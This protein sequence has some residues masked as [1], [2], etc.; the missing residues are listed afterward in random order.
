[1]R[2][3]RTANLWDAPA[4]LPCSITLRCYQ[5]AARAAVHRAH[6]TVRSTLVVLPTGTG[7]TALAGALGLDVKARGSRTLFLA[8]TITLCDQTYESM[9]RMGLTVGVEQADR[10]VAWPLPDVVV[11]SVATMRGKRLQT[12]PRDAFALIVVD[13][14]HRAPG[15]TL[16]AAIL[17]HFEGA[18]VVGLSATPDRTDGLAMANV[19]ESTAYEMT[20]L[21]AM[22]AGWLAPLDI[23]TAH[24]QWDVQAIKEKAGEVDPLSVAAEL[25]RSGLLHDAARTLAELGGNR[26]ML[27]FLPTVN[28]SKAFCVELEAAGLSCAHVDGET[29]PLERQR[30]YDAFRAG[31][32][33]VLVNCAVLTEGFDQPDVSVV[34]LLSPTKSRSRLTQMIGR[35]TRTAEGKASCLVLDFCPGRLTKGRLA[36]PADALAGRMLPD[37]VHAQL[38]AEGNLEQ[39]IEKAELTAEQIRKAREEREERAAKRREDRAR[40][41]ALVRPRRVTWDVERHDADDILGGQGRGSSAGPSGSVGQPETDEERRRRLKLATPKQA[42]VLARY[43]LNPDM[44]FFLARAA[45]DAIVAAGWKLPD[46]IR[47]DRRFYARPARQQAQGAAR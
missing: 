29:P 6:E 7:K 13:E 41:K 15:G 12:F 2:Y 44:P 43:G 45:M 16:Y 17:A 31:T 22:R 23:Q 47:D 42:K 4:P 34:A 20:M 25:V 9:R 3:L 27:A 46:H 21:A 1:M 28:T 8:P 10:E 35:G 36:S 39:L 40:L 30:I 24:T 38:G 32:I 18:K 33:R 37:D 14:A 5:E 26:K 11:A 19:F